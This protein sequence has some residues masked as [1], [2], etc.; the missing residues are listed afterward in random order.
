M[1]LAKKGYALLVAAVMLLS[2]VF[3]VKAAED[4]SKAEAAKSGVVQI[5]TVFVDEASEKHVVCGGTGILIGDAEGTE[6]VITCNHLVTPSEETKNAAFEFYGIANTDDAW[7][8]INLSTEVVV[9]GDV[10][11]N[12]SILTVSEELD[13]VVL[14]LSQPIYTKTPLTILTQKSYDVENL[15]YGVTEAVYALGYP[16][17]ISF[18]SAVQYYSDSQ[19]AMNAGHIVNLLNFEGVQVIESDV[20]S[21]VNN[22]GGPLVNQN[23]YVIGMNLGIK[24][25]MYSCAL[26]STKITKVL[27]GL[28]IKY[29]KIGKNPV[30]I[31][32]DKIIN[33]NPKPVPEKKSLPIYLIVII[34]VAAV[35]IVAGIIT[36]IILLVLKRDSNPE[37]KQKKEKPK[38]ADEIKKEQVDSILSQYVSVAPQPTNF[39][40][41]SEEGSDTMVLGATNQVNETSVLN[42]STSLSEQLKTGSLIRRKT[43]EKITI[44]KKYFTIGKDSLHVD[45]CIKDNGTISRQHAIIRQGK[46]GIYLEDCNST[47]GTWLNGNKVGNGNAELLKNGDIIKISNEEFEY[48]V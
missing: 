13:M 8:K 15:P 32:K 44:T 4:T 22:Y 20:A 14:Q 10:V 2:P 1:K 42:P 11:L 3:T 36:I 47:N 30:V 18:D 28:G 45:Y 12:A 25:G 33:T 34:I 9:E 38:S 27:D 46:G 31:E 39:G 24:D 41:S 7:S 40:G 17:G 23:G 48:Q 29:S 6:Y 21:D 16:D 37:K 5:N 43:G 35:V 19:V 26:D